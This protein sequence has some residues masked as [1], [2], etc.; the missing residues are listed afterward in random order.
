VALATDYDC[1]HKTEEAVT[2]EA[3]LSTLRQN[4]TLAKRLLRTAMPA[5][6]DVKDCGCQRALQDAIVTASDQMPASLMRKLALL[7]D[8]V[9]SAKKEA[10]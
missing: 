2:V 7:M 8:R 6:A 1:W 9:I 3:I 10:R 4:V 5:V